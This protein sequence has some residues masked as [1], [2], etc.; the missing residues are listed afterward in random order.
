MMTAIAAFQNQLPELI[1]SMHS[2]VDLSAQAQGFGYCKFFV[3]VIL[4]SLPFNNW[5]KMSIFT[6]FV[7]VRLPIKFGI[8]IL[9]F[10]SLWIE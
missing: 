10:P 7:Q 6:Q 8:L 1:V 4:L 2:G 9:L 5:T 3:P